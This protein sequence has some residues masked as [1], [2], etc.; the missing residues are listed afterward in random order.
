MLNFFLKRRFITKYRGFLESSFQHIV[1]QMC[2]N[3][4]LSVVSDHQAHIGT[5]LLDSARLLAGLQVL[6]DAAELL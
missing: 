6:M 5:S 1:R 2:Q 4:R 3:G